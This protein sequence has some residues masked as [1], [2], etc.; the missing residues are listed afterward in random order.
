MKEPPD[1]SNYKSQKRKEESLYSHIT[2]SKEEPEWCNN[3]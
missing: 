2:Y 1:K 3:E